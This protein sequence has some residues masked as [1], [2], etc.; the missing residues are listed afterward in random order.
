MK[1][2][3]NRFDH[4]GEKSPQGQMNDFINEKG[5]KKEDV[6][7]ITN[8]LFGGVELWYWGEE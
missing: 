5:I 8:S 4:Y 1:I 6:I 7:S 2:K 3:V